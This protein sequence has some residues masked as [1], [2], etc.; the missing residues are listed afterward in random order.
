MASVITFPVQSV[1]RGI[2][3]IVVKF[4][5]DASGTVSSAVGDRVTPSKVGTGNWRLTFS[6]S[7]PTLVSMDVSF[8]PDSP[9]DQIESVGAWSSSNKTLD[10]KLY[11]VSGSALANAAGTISFSVHFQNVS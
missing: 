1:M 2:V 10:I 5:V 8:Q 6:D 9:G 11:D 4:D 3:P 7:F